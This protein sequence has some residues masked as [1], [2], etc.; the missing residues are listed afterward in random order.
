M[1]RE[2]RYALIRIRKGEIM[3]VP[4]QGDKVKM[5]LNKMQ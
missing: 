1:K 4:Q 3:K 5:K 2:F